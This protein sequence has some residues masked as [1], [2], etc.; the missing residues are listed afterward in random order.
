MNLFSSRSVFSLRKSKHILRHSFH[1]FTR[2]S[3]K[4]SKETRDHIAA[5]LEAL[6]N[7]ILEKNREKADL[8]AKETVA[9]TDLHLKKNSYDHF[10]ELIIAI[11]FALTVAILVRQMWFEPY[12]IP[13]GSMR[14]TLKEQDRLIVSKTN[15]GI[16]FPLRATHLYFNPDLVQRNGIFVFTGANMDI[17]DVDTMYFYLFPGKKQYIK[18]LMGKPGDILYFYGGEIYGVDKD[19][20]DISSSLQLERLDRIEHIPFID[21]DRKIIVP[22][23]ATQGVYSPVFFYQMNEPIAKLFV[24]KAGNIAGE[25]LDMPTIHAPNTPPMKDYFDIWGMKNFGMGRLLTKEQ[26]KQFTRFDVS[27]LDNGVLYLEITHH[28][29][30]AN[31][32]LIR[33]EMGRIRPT[34]SKST[35]LIPLKEEHLKTL[36]NNMYT[37][38]FC[39]RN[40]IAYR[41][42]SNEEQALKNS[43]APK[44]ADVADGCYEFYYGKASE[45]KWQGITSTLPPSHPLNQYSPELVQL[46]YNVGIEWDM[47]FMP[48]YKDQRLAPSRYAYFR[49]GDL[50]LLGAPIFKKDDPVLM[51]FLAQ[52]KERQNASTTQAPF[53]P[54]EDNGAPL[55]ADGSLN[56]DLIKQYGLLISDKSYLALGDNHAMSSDSRDF[57][58]VPESNL[59][60]GPDFI[61]WPPGSRWGL[62]N[63]PL[64]PFFNTPR[65]IV[66]ILAAICITL[67]VR[68]WRKRNR[69]PLPINKE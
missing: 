30:F 46:L 65:V 51:Q 63:Q 48:Q 16:N 9:V 59:R 18:R 21:F 24:N 6:Q 33:D 61:F 4:L 36:L 37:A 66:W 62:P 12:E 5:T 53:F 49:N 22:P 34:L 47:R 28:P 39:V 29:S 69:L 13:T 15:F 45:V 40:G 43:F 20:K 14:P 17:R 64:Y 50:Y 31:A 54:F 26:V 7:A 35:S 27:K 2:K 11:V 42:G 52:E 60:G 3:K 56:K 38:R 19:G 1:L 44:L 32:K 57:G 41:Y 58:F 25:I 55:L 68:Y 67:C 8:L 10:R 23:A